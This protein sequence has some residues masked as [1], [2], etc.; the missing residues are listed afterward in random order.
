[1]SVG[2]Q[3]IRVPLLERLVLLDLAT[4]WDVSEEEALRR[5]IADA[6]RREVLAER[7][8]EPARREEVTD[9]RTG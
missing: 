3:K 4:R 8:S 1:M 5:V 6:A 2:W 7:P 9:D